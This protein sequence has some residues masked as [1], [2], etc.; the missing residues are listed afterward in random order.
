MLSK[1]EDITSAF[2]AFRKTAAVVP[3]SVEAKTEATPQRVVAKL[4]YQSVG[5]CPYCAEPMSRILCCGQEV[6]LCIN[7]RMVTPLP[8]AELPE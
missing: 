7:D 1:P 6:F 4:N 8:N 2:A 5:V 3:S